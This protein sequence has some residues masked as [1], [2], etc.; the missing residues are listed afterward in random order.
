MYPVYDYMGSKEVCEIVHKTFPPQHQESQP[1]FEYLMSPPP[2]SAPFGE[3]GCRRLEGRTAVIT[4]GDSGIG[5]A[6]AYAYAAE[7][8]RVLIAYLDEHQDALRTKQLIEETGGQCELAAGDLGRPEVAAM[9]AETA[10]ERFGS[11][12]ILVNNIAVQ[13]LKDSIL[14]I[15]KQQLE[16]T[17]RTN[18]FS[19]FYMIQA[20]LPK[21]K[22]G[23]VII[24]TASVTAF[25]GGPRLLDYS[26]SKGAVVSL[27]RSLALSLVKQG[28]RVN[29]V[30]P[31][32]VW[33]P[34]I[35]ASY[36]AEE[37]ETFG[38]GTSGVPMGRAA[39]PF[40][41]AASYVFLASDES[42]YM[43]GQILHPN[44]GEIV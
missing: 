9:V 38:S 3:R 22:S 24:N 13:F 7:G 18:V 37:V 39:Q 35:P 41:I 30:A 1:G 16:L 28:I 31:G 42:R 5:R 32:P 4:G 19:Y 15:S 25:T 40:E 36:S 26:A 20:A 29:A 8:A 17:F 33:T 23:G 14:E 44:G 43:T 2:I 11:I 34:L 10:M 6:V 12:D 21:M 27:T